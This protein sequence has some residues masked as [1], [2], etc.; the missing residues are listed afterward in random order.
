MESHLQHESMFWS[1][2]FLH[3]YFYVIIC[4]NF[5]EV[6]ELYFMTS[7]MQL[8]CYVLE[9]EKKKA[10]SFFQNQER[11]KREDLNKPRN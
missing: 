9:N 7:F 3:G 5:Y 10:K 6:Y 8:E 1:V 4:F 11:K 2:Y